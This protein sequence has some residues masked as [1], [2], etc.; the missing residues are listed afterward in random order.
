MAV[1]ILY[2]D[3]EEDL[4]ML[5]QSQLLLDGY[6]VD[7]VGEGMAA[8]ERIA[9]TP[10]DVV[11]LDLHLQDMGGDE[12]V[13]ELQRRGLQAN[14]VIL[15]GDTSDDA[16]ERCVA[17]GATQFLHKPF[18]FKELTSSIK[19]ALAHHGGQGRNGSPDGAGGTIA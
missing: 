5:I 11:L 13:E 12:V 6:E 7:V 1:R 9:H 16:R 4:R 2:I 18:H 10:Y 14:I 17:L 19:Y 8:V 3:D 15:T